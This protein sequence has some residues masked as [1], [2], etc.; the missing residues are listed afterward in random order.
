MT[1]VTRKFLSVSDETDESLSAMLF[2][3]LRAQALG[4]GAVV[5]R[6]ARPTARFGWIGLDKDITADAV[7]AARVQAME[8]LR[9]VEAKTGVTPELRVSDEDP[10]DA[11]RRLVDE[12]PSIHML[13]L[14]AGSGPRGPGPLVTQLAKG[15]PLAGRPIAVVVVPAGITEDQLR[16]LSSHSG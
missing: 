12:D 5:L 8:H 10:P 6:C 13:V 7:D 9:E 2:A 1:K 15:R 3:A 16:D 14:A 11:I 4:M